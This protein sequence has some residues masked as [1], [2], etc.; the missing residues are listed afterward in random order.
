MLWEQ[1]KSLSL[2]TI[3]LQYIAVIKQ[4]VLLWEVALLDTD[5]RHFSKGLYSVTGLMKAK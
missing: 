1:I 2:G 3:A 5:P 4:F